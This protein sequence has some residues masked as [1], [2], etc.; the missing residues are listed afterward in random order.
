MNDP[1]K[2]L[3]DELRSLRPRRPSNDLRAKIGERLSPELKRTTPVAVRRFAWIGAAAAACAVIGLLTWRLASPIQ[4][5]RQ[6]VGLRLPESVAAYGDWPTAGAYSAA[7]RRSPQ[8]LDALLIRHAQMFLPP[9]DLAQ[10]RASAPM[11]IR[12]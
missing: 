7:L 11:M 8:E 2:R 6:S 4:P 9:M 5:V 12:L 1:L 3:E 10:A